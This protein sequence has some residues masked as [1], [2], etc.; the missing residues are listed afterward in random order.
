MEKFWEQYEVSID[1]RSHIAD[2][3]KLAYRRH[4]LKNGPARHVVE[5]LSGTGNDYSV[6][7]ECLQKCYDKQKWFNQVHVRV[8]IEAPTLKEGNGKELQCL[9]DVS[10]QHLRALKAMIMILWGLSSHLGLK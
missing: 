10:I 1:S 8:I 6:A 4:S 7:L 3:K 5:R 2:H 9:H